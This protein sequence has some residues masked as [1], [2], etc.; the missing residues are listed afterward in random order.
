MFH[1]KT[2]STPLRQA[3]PLYPPEIQRLLELSG[4]GVDLDTWLTGA[5]SS[6][7]FLNDN[8][9]AER[10]ALYASLPHVLIHGVLAPLRQLTNPDQTKLGRDFVGRRPTRPRLPSTALERG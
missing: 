10:V 1:V 8:V 7:G 9:R 2:S 3:G 4:Q 6:V 5:E